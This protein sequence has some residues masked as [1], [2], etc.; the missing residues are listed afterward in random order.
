MKQPP[1][2]F[3]FRSNTLVRTIAPCIA[4][5]RHTRSEAVPSAGVPKTEIHHRCEIEDDQ[6]ELQDLVRGGPTIGGSP[7]SVE[8]SASSSV[9]APCPD[10]GV[11]PVPARCF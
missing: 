7:A 8:R 1:Y 6:E 2:R 9:P 3:T 11:T 5:L 4:S 10:V